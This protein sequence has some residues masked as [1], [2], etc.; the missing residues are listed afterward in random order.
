MWRCG[1]LF[2]I[3]KYIFSKWKCVLPYSR[4]S[5][6][7]YNNLSYHYS[8]LCIILGIQKG[9]YGYYNIILPRPTSVEISTG[10]W[11]FCRMHRQP[12]PRW[13]FRSTGNRHPASVTS[14]ER[15]LCP[16][17]TF[18]TCWRNCEHHIIYDIILCA[19]IYCYAQ[20]D[21]GIQLCETVLLDLTA[22]SRK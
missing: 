17:R 8:I 19:G 3:F 10:S 12:Y 13:S 21:F 20:H 2:I 15:H 7:Y 6:I 16:R 14:C 11:S 5:V 1:V 4:R 18:S 22:S 9:T